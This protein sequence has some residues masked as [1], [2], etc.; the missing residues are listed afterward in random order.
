M[1]NIT[2]CS[3]QFSSVQ[4]LSCVQLF[5]T[6]WI[7]AHQASLSITNSR[8]SL[9]HVHRVSDAIQ[10]SH[11]LLSPSP[12]I[13]NPSQPSESFPMSQFFTSGGQNIGVSALA[14]VLPMNI[15]GWFPLGLTGLIMTTGK[16]LALARWNL[17]GKVMSLCFNMLS[18]FVIAFLP[19]S[20]CLL[21]SC[22]QWFG[23]PRK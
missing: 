5:A 6:P 8:S 18:R 14:S 20:K 11:P 2:H 3:V 16:T 10:P 15:Q 1:L 19:R 21:I 23:V 9:R 7:T 12:P 4:S 13:P 22:L 17:V